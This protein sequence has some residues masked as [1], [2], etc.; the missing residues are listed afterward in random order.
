MGVSRLSSDK[1]ITHILN[2]CM[3]AIKN[4]LP[5][6]AKVSSPTLITQPFIQNHLSVLIGIIGDE[7]GRIL[8]EGSEDTFARIGEKMF[9][10]QIEGEMLESFTGELGNMICGN[11]T[12]FTS[13]RGIH[14]DIT[15]PTVILGE[16]KIYGFSKGINL[17]INLG[18]YGTMNILLMIEQK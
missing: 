10:M 7:R 9:G 18:S 17:P 5:M 8:I 12:T 4:V 1:N 14:L 11:L 6:E 3:E 2:A 13:N 16:T 15:P